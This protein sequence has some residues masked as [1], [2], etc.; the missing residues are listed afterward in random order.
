[1]SGRCFA[2]SEELGSFRIHTTHGSFR[3]AR[4]SPI[5]WAAS[6]RADCIGA[7]DEELDLIAKSSKCS[8]EANA[9]RSIREQAST[10]WAGGREAL[11]AYVTRRKRSFQARRRQLEMPRSR[12]RSRT[13]SVIGRVPGQDE[14]ISS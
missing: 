8:K 14:A 3:C 13:D 12:L 10:A 9:D 2:L 1:M 11:R 6:A 5:K 7:S 4:R